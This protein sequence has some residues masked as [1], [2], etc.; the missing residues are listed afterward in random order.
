MKFNFFDRMVSVKNG[1]NMKTLQEV[2][3]IKNKTDD[4]NLQIV[5][6]HDKNS[7]CDI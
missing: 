6:T 3:K 2:K 5:E 7:L 1:K 4:K